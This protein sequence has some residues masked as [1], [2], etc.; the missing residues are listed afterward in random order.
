MKQKDVDDVLGGQGAWDNVDQTAAQCPNAD[1]EG[2]GRKLFV[3]YSTRLTHRRIL[4][5][6]ADSLSR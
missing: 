2:G 6:A 3:S 5:S 4:L 1:C